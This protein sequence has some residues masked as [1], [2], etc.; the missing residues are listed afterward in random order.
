VCKKIK[1]SPET[2]HVPVVFVSSRDERELVSEGRQAGGD[3]YVCKPVDPQD[4]GADLYFLFDRNFEMDPATLSRL[5]VCK[6]ISTKKAEPAATPARS[7]APN[8]DP[9]PFS[10][11]AEIESFSPPDSH[12]AHASAQRSRSQEVTAAFQQIYKMLLSVQ[13][14]I[15]TDCQSG[16]DSGEVLATTQKRLDAILQYIED[17]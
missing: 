5:R 9:D 8:H 2:C 1:A 4:L 7:S 14:S 17:Q 11:D 6:Q 3:F 10:D 16:Q 15:A 13:E 12:E